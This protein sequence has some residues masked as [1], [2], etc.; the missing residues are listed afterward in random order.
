M[1]IDH[2]EMSI[3][4]EMGTT[5]I[6]GKKIE[7]TGTSGLPALP[8]ITATAKPAASQSSK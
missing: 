5:E 1:L 6:A 7:L 4:C 2:K 3:L 8:H